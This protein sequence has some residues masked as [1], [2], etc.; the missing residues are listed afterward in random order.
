MDNHHSFIGGP[1]G[2]WRV[3]KILPVL[4]EVLPAVTHLHVVNAPKLAVADAGQWLLQGFTSNVR[5]AVRSEVTQLRASQEGLGRSASTLAALIPIKKNAAWWAM[6]QDERRAVFEEQSHHTAVGLE[7]LP[8]VARQLM[9]SRDL[10]EPF[11]FLTWFEFA[12][13]HEASF[14]GLLARLRAS[15][16]WTYVE[17]E[18]DIRLARA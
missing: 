7:Y 2:Q 1:Q 9:H 17:R 6:P 14:D 10:G 13:E 5:Y 12:P 8:Q 18:V 4:G 3:T 11:D 16:E 15:P